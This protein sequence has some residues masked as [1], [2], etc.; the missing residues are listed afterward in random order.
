MRGPLL[1]PGIPAARTRAQQFDEH[2]LDVVERL[3]ARWGEQLEDLEFAVEDVP[4]ADPSP[5]EA[6]EVPLG[7]FFPADRAL[8][9]RVVLY[10]RP[11]EL[12]AGSEMG[13]ADLVR[14]VLVE[15]VAH[16]L[17]V[18]ADELDPGYRDD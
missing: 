15:Q 1:P 8:A 16:A 11:V 13:L 2:V 14:T 6:G 4:P 9:P 10:R 3:G 7:R 17:G 18:P 12:R 5:W